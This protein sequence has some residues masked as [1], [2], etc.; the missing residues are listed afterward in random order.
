MQRELSFYNTTNEVGENLSEYQGK[1][2]SQDENVL[3]I[4]KEFKNKQIT[5]ELAL[6]ELQ[7]QYPNRYTNTPLTSVRR[8]FSNLKKMGLIKKNDTKALG[9]YG[10]MVF[11][12]KLV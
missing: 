12:W 1:A 6:K 9:D 7:L 10:R 4:F 2:R 8:S 11:T 3:L 5:P